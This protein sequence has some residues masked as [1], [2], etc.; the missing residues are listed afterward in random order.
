MFSLCIQ[1]FIFY[2]FPVKYTFLSD[3]NLNFLNINGIKEFLEIFDARYFIFQWIISAISQSALFGLYLFFGY[4]VFKLYVTEVSSA[5]INKGNK[6]FLK[7]KIT[8]TEI[9]IYVIAI[10]KAY[11]WMNLLKKKDAAAVQKEML[12]KDPKKFL[13]DNFKPDPDKNVRIIDKITIKL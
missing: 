12:T 7:F 10:K 13:R 5:K 6:N 4:F 8:D 11:K 2:L 3:D 9:V 1:L